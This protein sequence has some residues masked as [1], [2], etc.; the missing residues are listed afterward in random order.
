LYLPDF[1]LPALSCWLEV[2]GGPVTDD[3]SHKAYMLCRSTQ[4]MV[5]L[6]GDH[7][8]GDQPPKMWRWNYMR[9]INDFSGVRNHPDMVWAQCKR[10]YVVQPV[11]Y[12]WEIQEYSS[13]GEDN[14]C[15]CVDELGEEFWSQETE[16]ISSAYSKARRARFEHGEKP[17]R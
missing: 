14:L 2:K 16:V 13:I 6:A 9:S 7:F 10:C 15:K 4:K 5:L 1:Y 12:I 17:R 3:A 11:A 8:N